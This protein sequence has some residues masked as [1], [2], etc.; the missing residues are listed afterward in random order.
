VR[1]WEDWLVEE[2]DSAAADQMWRLACTRRSQVLA[3]FEEFQ[4]LGKVEA[5][6]VSAFRRIERPLPVRILLV[7]GPLVS[8][9]RARVRILIEGAKDEQAAG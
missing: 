1:N 6:S 4:W 9:L 3:L 7:Y 2:K 5:C 8:E